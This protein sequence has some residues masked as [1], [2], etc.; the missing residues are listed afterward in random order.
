MAQIAKAAG[1]SQGAISSLLN[2][3]DYG[4]RVS[5]KTRERVFKVCREMGY[6]P[7]DLRAVVRMYPEMG[8]FC[9]LLARDLGNAAAEPALARIASATVA[10]VPSDIRALTISRYDAQMDYHVD[11]EKL[12]QPVRVGVASKFIGYGQVNPSL[13]AA[14]TRRGWPFVLLGA[15][16]KQVGVISLV[17]DYAQASVLALEHLAKLGHERIAIVSGPFGA[18][19]PAIIEMN[20]GV[21]LA[22]EKMGVPLEAQHVVYGDLSFAAGLAAVDSL[23]DRKS[24]P[25]AVYCMSDSVAAGVIARA[26]AKGIKIP[27]KLSV[28]GCGDDPV[29]GFTAPSL[30][31]MHIPL[32]AMATQAVAE[33]DRLIR[34]NDLPEN[35]TVV[36]PVHLVERPS[37]GSA[38][39]S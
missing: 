9:L 35:R 22:F 18:S 1:V 32:E 36:V 29:C 2:D 34:F 17:P 26:S 21:R 31:T 19:D 25:T 24:A 14:V 10:A 20:R 23:F 15:S 4:I 16:F 6:L 30:A 13:I 27:E 8:E 37:C 33:V 3:R 38:P 11:P 12:P 7:N 5:D 28:I 39:R